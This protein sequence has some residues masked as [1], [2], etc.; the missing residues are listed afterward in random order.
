[1]KLILAI[2]SSDDAQTVIR[3][4]SQ[5]DFSVTKLATSG[6]FLMAGNV[7]IITGVEDERVDEAID[8]IRNTSMSRKQPMPAITD[9]SRGGFFSSPL[10]EVTV[11]GATIFV[12]PVER[13]EKI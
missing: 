9:T 2:I 4:L 6:G 5:A 10:V 3:S 8:I 12:L 1:M 13:F 11:G 7:T